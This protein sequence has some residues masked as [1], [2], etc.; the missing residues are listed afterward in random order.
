MIYFLP[1]KLVILFYC[2]ALYI[3]WYTKTK[4][5]VSIPFTIIYKGIEKELKKA[6][7]TFTIKA[8]KKNTVDNTLRF[9]VVLFSSLFNPIDN[10]NGIPINK[11]LPNAII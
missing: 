5:S 10:S 11:K 6:N 7:T 4:R 3:L 1:N 8:I 2:F 9:I